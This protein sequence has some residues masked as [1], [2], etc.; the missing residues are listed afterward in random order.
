MCLMFKIHNMRNKKTFMKSH[1]RSDLNSIICS[2]AHPSENTVAVIGSFDSVRSDSLEAT[3]CSNFCRNICNFWQWFAEESMKIILGI[4][5]DEYR[6]NQN[7]KKVFM[8]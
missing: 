6:F 3:A 5:G 8:F 7:K 2:L 1:I 4:K